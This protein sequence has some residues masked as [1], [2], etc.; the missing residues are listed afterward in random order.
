ME[1]LQ[2]NLVES[3]SQIADIVARQKA[4]F[5]THKT[6]D[7][8]FRLQK[9][10]DL[11]KAIQRYEGAIFEALEKDFRKSTFETFATE[12]ALILDEIK[13]MLENVRQW[14]KPQ[15]VRGSWLLF[16]SSSYLYPEPYGTVLVI[17]AWNYPLQLTIV[18]A[19]GAIAAGNCVIIKPSELA[20]HTSA[21]IKKIISEVF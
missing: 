1:T 5:R 4:F 21:V 19:V 7:I 18:P 15:P 16:P 17:G 13:I 3:H 8:S 14:A 10:K 6:L 12:I 2:E 9:L 11:Q 20:S